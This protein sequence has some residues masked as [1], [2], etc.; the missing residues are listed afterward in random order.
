MNT[1]T[2]V[3]TMN[4]QPQLTTFTDWTS[5]RE[6]VSLGTNA[7][8]QTL[9]FQGW[10]RIKESFAPEL[11]ARAVDETPTQVRRCID[12]F[13]GSG[14]TGIACQFLGV[15]PILVEVNPYLADLIEAKLTRYPSIDNLLRDLKAVVETSGPN[16]ENLIE[17]YF[18]TS[19]RT[20]VQ[21]GHNGRWL[22]DRNVAERIVAIRNAIAQL[23]DPSRRLF[24]V[25]LGGVLIEVSNVRVSGKGR[26]Y[27]RRW[28]ERTVPPDRVERLFLALARQAISEISKFQRRYTTSYEMLR[29]DSRI[30]LHDVEPC[31]LAV[32]S[33]PYP[34]SFD[35]TDV[36]NVELWSLGYL[37]SMHANGTLRAATLSSHVQVSRDFPKPPSGSPT[38]S[39]VLTR[40]EEKQP[41]LWDPMIPAMVGAYFSDLKAV[42]DQLGR[43]LSSGG[44]AW[45]VVGDSR[46]AGVQV[47]VASVLEE[48]VVSDGWDI[49]VKEPFR[50]MRSSAQQGGERTLTEH[51]LVLRR[52]G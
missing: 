43:I 24:R 12:P 31:D 46:Y 3:A 19:P 49:L 34:N 27:R 21:P 33:P 22:F 18:G 47:P 10:R 14:T 39:D 2:C 28:D 11:V 9:P 26:R 7:G 20:F 36:Y 48:L 17:E 6:L 13:G 52:G 51:L 15:H 23:D 25:L 50:S 30:A 37:D 4:Q 45:M 8:A 42:L 41:Q 32:F 1:R 38:L 5:N 16:A 44:S 40:L 29:G 35:Y